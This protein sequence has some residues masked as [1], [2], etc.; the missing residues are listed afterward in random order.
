[1]NSYLI[2]EYKKGKKMSQAEISGV[3]LVK[4]LNNENG[5][6]IFE[7]RTKKGIVLVKGTVDMIRNGDTV[8]CK[9]FMTT[10]KNQI[11]NLGI[12]YI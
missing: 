3:A 8:T 12:L 11:Q 10:D 9:G 1:L 2:K 4:Y 6:S 5:Y 7:V